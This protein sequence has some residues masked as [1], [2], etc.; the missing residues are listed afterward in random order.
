MSQAVLSGTR[1]TGGS[2]VK[3]MISRCLW[4]NCAEV[5]W[6]AVTSIERLWDYKVLTSP[7]YIVTLT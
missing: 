1:L 3:A 5:V 4:S 6:G 7:T 2:D